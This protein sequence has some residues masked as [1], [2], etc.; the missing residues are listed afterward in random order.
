METKA[1]CAWMESM[2]QIL[3]LEDEVDIVRKVGNVIEDGIVHQL[4]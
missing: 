3:V 4:I 2:E 1:F